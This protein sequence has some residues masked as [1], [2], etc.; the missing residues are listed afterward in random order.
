MPGLTIVRSFWWEKGVLGLL[1]SVL[2]DLMSVGPELF[3]LAGAPEL[4]RR[5][6]LLTV[7]HGRTVALVEA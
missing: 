7:R 2:V 3:L 4:P 6:R 5:R 1:E